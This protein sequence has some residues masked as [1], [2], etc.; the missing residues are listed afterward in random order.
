M[1]VVRALG[2]GRKSFD[3]PDNRTSSV[4]DQE[5]FARTYAER[6]GLNFV[7]WYADDGVTGGTMERP[8]LKHML[9]M[10][11]RGDVD[12][13]IIEDVDRLSRDQEHLQYMSKLLRLHRVTL[14]TVAAGVIDHLVLSVKGMI[15]EQQRMRIAYTTRRGL[16]GKAKRGGATGGKTL[17]YARAIDPQDPSSDRLIVVEGEAALVRRIF[18]LYGD[19]SSLKQICNLL[20]E[21]GVPTPRARE[22]GKY[23]AGVWNPSTLSGSAELGEGILN[24]ETYIG[25]RIFNRRT[26]IEVPNETRGFR[27]RPRLNPECD[28][29]IRDEPDLRIIDQDLWLCVKRRQTEARAARD[30]KF[31]L[32]A[33]PLS[34]AKRPAHLL[35]GLV[36]CG[37]CGGVFVGTG[38]RWRCKAA[39]RQACTN[40]SIRITELEDRVLSGVRDRLL[41]PAVIERFATALQQELDADRIASGSERAGLQAQLDEVRSRIARLARRLEED[42]DAP[43][44]LVERLKELESQEFDLVGALTEVP[45]QTVVQLPS[46]YE[47]IYRRAVAELE[48]HLASTDGQAAKEAVRALI[49]RV[50][51]QPGDARGGKRRPIQLHGDLFEMLEFASAAGSAGDKRKL[52]R[53]VGSGGVVTPLVAGTGFE[54]VTFRL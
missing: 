1:S 22:R 31:K 43:R 47:P 38:G 2:Y 45:E 29:I 14:H 10:I 40:A 30:A 34:G 25:R 54:P 28:W 41:T 26:W 48:Q 27:R 46:N 5:M 17:G 24:N 23:N 35:S 15:G 50:V 13:V 19:G 9:D 3:D 16:A 44:T 39:M 37:C 7:S 33:N 32:T 11:R 52:P 49:E 4:A 8:G 51:I 53:T 21:E 42:E 6:N 12:A 36:T 18:E 20:N